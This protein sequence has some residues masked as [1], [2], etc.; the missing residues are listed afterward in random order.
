MKKILLI[1]DCQVRPGVPLEYLTSIGNY[2]IAKKPDYI[3]CIGDFADMPSLSS[4]DKAGSKDLEGMRYNEDIKSVWE[5]MGNLIG[6]LKSYKQRHPSY[7]PKLIMTLGNHE[8]RITR[9]IKNDPRFD[10]TIGLDDLAYKAMGWKVY[11]FLQPV[12]ICGI[13]FCHYFCSGIMGRPIGTARALL[14]KM[15]VSCVAGHLPGRDIAF[16]RRADGSNMTGLIVGSCYDYDMPYLNHQTNAVWHGV[17]MLHNCQ[18]GE[19]DEMSVPLSF[20]KKHYL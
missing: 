19:F 9:A 20:L 16:A 8:D 7:K 17:Y 14:S 13:T 2:I 1:P 4:H 12:T 18:N 15:H 3:V 11:P 6:P 10:K 5:G